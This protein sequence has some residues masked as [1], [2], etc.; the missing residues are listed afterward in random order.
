MYRESADIPTKR[1]QF[2]KATRTY[3]TAPRKT[4]FLRGPIPL[5]WLGRAAALP[6]KTLHLALALQW[7]AGMSKGE[8]FKLSKKALGIFHVSRD[9]ASDGLQRLEEAG[10]ISVVRKPGQRP[11]IVIL[12]AL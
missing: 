12:A 5:S 7:L 9:A 6:G 8:P 4:L 1:L 10:L 11:T 3:I 2:D